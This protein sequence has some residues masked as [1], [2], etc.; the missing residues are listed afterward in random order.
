MQK[1]EMLLLF[2]LLEDKQNVNKPF[3][4]IS[5]ETGMSL[6]SVQMKYHELVEAGYIVDASRG[7]VIRKRSQLIERWT[8]GYADGLRQKYLIF[9]FRFLAPSV[10]E[11]WRDIHLPRGICWGGEPVACLLTEYIRPEKWTIYVPD[12]ADALISTGR[13]VPDKNGEIYVYKKFWLSEGVPP[14]V[15]Y[16][17]LLAM[18][19]DRCTETAD[20]IRELL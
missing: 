9:R 11:Q 7:K 8:R 1:S 6:G 13:M 3:R 15:V 20:R 12:K 5:K 2:Y 18:N 14:M 4:T 19:E 17:D 10:R 16:A